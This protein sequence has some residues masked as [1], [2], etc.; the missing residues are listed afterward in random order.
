MS[1][2]PRN[3]LRAWLFLV[4][5]FSAVILFAVVVGPGLRRL[6]GVRSVTGQTE[7]SGIDA[8]SLFYTETDAFDRANLRSR[9]TFE[10]DHN[11][12]R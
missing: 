2:L 9:A 6:P 7:A 3:R 8:G 12:S 1:A 4:L 5:A 10:G 11:P